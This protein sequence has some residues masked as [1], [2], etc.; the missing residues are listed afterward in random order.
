MP[1]VR[2]SL[3]GR[4]TAD[5]QADQDPPGARADGGRFP[6][7]AQVALRN[8]ETQSNPWNLPMQRAKWAEGLN[9]PTMAEKSDVEYL[10]FVGCAGAFD[11]RYQKVSRA[12]VKILEEAGISYA[13]LGEEEMCTGD[14]AKRI[15]NELLAQMMMQ[16]NVETFNNYGVKKVLTTCPHCF[17]SIKNE[18]PPVGGEYEVVHHTDLI[19]E[20]IKDGK[21]KP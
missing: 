17:N 12:M 15:G 19:N 11:Q 18:L 1:R 20:L 14:S 5:D 21:L 16:Q 9:V 6:R 7:Q 3:P 10:W 2:G 4:D 8:I 13:I